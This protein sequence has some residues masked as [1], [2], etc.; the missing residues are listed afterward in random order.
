MIAEIQKEKSRER[1]SF[2]GLVPNETSNP[3]PESEKRKTNLAVEESSWQI[4]SI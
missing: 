4:V 3:F 1:P 2:Q